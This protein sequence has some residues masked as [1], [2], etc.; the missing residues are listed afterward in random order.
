MALGER[1]V[2]GESLVESVAGERLAK[3]R[4]QPLTLLEGDSEDRT[5]H[6]RVERPEV[7]DVIPSEGDAGNENVLDVGPGQLIPEV[8]D[9]IGHVRPTD[10]AVAEDEPVGGA[11][12]TDDGTGQHRGII[13]ERL[14]DA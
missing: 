14:R 2:G 8:D 11:V 4:S 3:R 12:H 9:G 7:E 13:G 5:F 1:L 10:C 6:R